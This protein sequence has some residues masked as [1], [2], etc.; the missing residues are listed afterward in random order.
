MNEGIGASQ[1]NAY[2]T[3]ATKTTGVKAENW[4]I[5]YHSNGK[6][7]KIMGDT[8]NKDKLY[9]GDNWGYWAFSDWIMTSR[10]WWTT[11]IHTEKEASII[12][13]KEQDALKAA[14]DGLRR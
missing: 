9:S 3:F 4:G 8:S 1:T 2:K 10:K 12:L 5:L 7:Y 6:I 14:D 11:W 13:K